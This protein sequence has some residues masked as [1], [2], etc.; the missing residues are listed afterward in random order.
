VN[1]ILTSAQ[2]AGGQAGTPLFTY[3]AGSPASIAQTLALDPNITAG[4]LAPV[5]PGPPVVSNGAALQLAGLGSST[6]PA[7]QI[8]GQ[9]ILQFLSDMAAQ[10]GQGAADAQDGNNLHTQLLAQSRSLQTQ[11]SGISLDA[12]AAQVLQLQQGYQAAGKMVSVINTLADTL[13]NM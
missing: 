4:T 10:A 8:S 9:T 1:S 7:D 12:E 3:G 13:L 2:T 6:N 5:N 11:V